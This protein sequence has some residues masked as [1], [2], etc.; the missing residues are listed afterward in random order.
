MCLEIFKIL[1]VCLLLLF[2][3]L[4]ESE[5]RIS[6]TVLFYCYYFETGPCQVAQVGFE[7]AVLLP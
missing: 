2:S 5:P 3:P 6:T 7:P 1:V 4:L